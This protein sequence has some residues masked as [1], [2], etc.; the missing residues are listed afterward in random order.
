MLSISILA[1][2]AAC[3]P[4]EEARTA[5]EFFSSGNPTFVLA[6]QGDEQA[7]RGVAG[8]VAFIR[9]LL[10][11]AA[12]VVD[13]ASIDVSAGASGWPERPV[14]YG[15]GHLN[16]ALGELT[17]CLPFKIGAGELE[18][19]GERY[20]G[21]EYRLIALVPSLAKTDSCAGSPQFML[22][23][24]AGTPGVT[25]INAT[26]D[27]GYGFVVIDRFGM[28]DAGVWERDDAGQPQAK[29]T[30]RAL[31]KP[32]RTTRVRAGE[33][34]L[35]G[36]IVARLQAATVS[37]AEGAQD[38][39]ILRG[40]QLARTRLGIENAKP[41]TV[42]LYADAKTKASI[43]RAGDG[44]ADQASRTLH[45]RAT[46]ASIG[47]SLEL[48]VAHEATHVL[49]DEAFG[50]S[51]C[52]LFG[53]GLAVWVSGHYGSRSMLEWRLDPPRV[54]P[55]VQQLSG[56][57]FRELAERRAYPIAGLFVDDLIH[58]HGLEAFIEHLY[59]AGPGGLDAACAALGMRVDALDALLR[60]YRNK[61][62]K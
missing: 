36:V 25:E 50:V 6:T 37:D 41:L 33:G 52:A 53:E 34:L 16:S 59:P 57:A 58:E 28:R 19:A 17:S 43:T 15:G 26:P 29:L 13:D 40:V 62:D 11:P 48:L 27:G 5:S 14:L 47:G 3:T 10:F 4:L 38:E 55:G 30:F 2:L 8:Q 18:I 39:A 60:R 22:Y 9:G 54:E 31:R 45:V 21:D 7:D 49:A 35:P 44:H 1:A 24:G 56:S 46:D 51:G 20:E 23:A 32:W 61:T 42:Y 12:A